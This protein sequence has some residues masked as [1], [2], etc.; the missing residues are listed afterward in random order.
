MIIVS[1]K[2]LGLFVFSFL[3][4]L[5]VTPQLTF[6]SSILPANE[7]KTIF[8][9]S[10]N[11]NNFIDKNGATVLNS[12]KSNGKDVFLFKPSI[13]NRT[14]NLPIG[15]LIFI[16]GSGMPSEMLVTP[17]KGVVEKPEGEYHLPK[18]VTGLLKVVG[19]GSAT[20]SVKTKNL[21]NT[22]PVYHSA[23]SSSNW[24][25][26]S[27][28][29]GFYTKV[30]SIWVVPVA[31][32][33]GGGDTSSSAWAGIDGANNAD[34]IQTGTDSDCTSGSPSYRAWWEI[35]P[36][37]ATFLNSFLYPVNPG[38]T[39]YAEI[40]K[41]SG[42]NWNITLKNLTQNWSFSTNQTYTGPQASVEWIVEAPTVGGSIAT[43]ANYGQMSF[44]NNTQNDVNP[45][46]TYATDSVELFQ[47]GS[48][49]SIASTPSANRNA[50]TVAYGSIAPTPPP[51]TWSATP[52]TSGASYRFA[53]A[54]L[55]TGKVYVMGGEGANPSPNHYNRLDE[56]TPGSNTWV[57]KKTMN[58]RRYSHTADTI[59][60]SGSAELILAV[61]GQGGP[62]GWPGGWLK[63]AELYNA[64][65]N[66]WTDTLDM[67]T[68]HSNHTSTVLDD[69]TVLVVGGH[70]NFGVRTKAVDL[71]DPIAN[72]W[73]VK[74]TMSAA[75]VYHTATKL[76]DGRV[77]VAG[78]QVTTTGSS[79]IATN[80]AII[81]DPVANTWIPT[82]GN[83]NTAR[84]NHKAVLLSGG[85]VM[86]MGGVDSSG[87]TLSSVE[88]W[89][90]ATDT[91]TTFTHMMYVRNNH[92]ATVLQNGNVL[93]VGGGTTNAL[94]NAEVYDPTL[95]TW[96]VIAAPLNPHSLH[97][98]NLLDSGNVLIVNGLISTGASNKAEYYVPQ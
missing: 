90:P 46:H 12:Q 84:L 64:S 10:N 63:S 42:S 44:I 5:L 35:L 71:Y 75:R 23:S 80:S 65:N 1:I 38:D 86:I 30:T 94:I 27:R 33:C 81:Y 77:L 25:G 41:I 88:I 76:N 95:D 24:S 54:K 51:A 48:V 49:V 87:N 13:N 70:G 69:G 19:K 26:Y 59:I 68:Y 89:Y 83:L 37:A 45:N 73:S 92:T 4:L 96:T 17:S 9:Q 7:T 40:R 62:S 57:S 74:A 98:A 39:M 61:G 56:Y 60:G 52:N 22:E 16:Y 36:S 28:L 29:T 8:V 85:R 50:F 67:S 11:P 34:L 14:A 72:T 66:T 21:L 31:T 93:V 55:S 53:S 32:D 15:T 97:T 82:T 3:C 18:G 58:V 78:G 2:K 6:A 79:G 43:L 20:V 91:W 47:G